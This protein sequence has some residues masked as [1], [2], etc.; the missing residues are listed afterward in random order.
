VFKRGEKLGDGAVHER[1]VA[2]LGAVLTPLPP[3]L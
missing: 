1:S 3:E 2:H